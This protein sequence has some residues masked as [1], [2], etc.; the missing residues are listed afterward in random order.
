M[1]D[2]IRL[3][4]DSGPV[5]LADVVEHIAAIATRRAPGM[6]VWWHRA[7]AQEWEMV[8]TYLPEMTRED[9]LADPFTV[10]QMLWEIGECKRCELGQSLPGGKVGECNL[11]RE[12]W[13]GEPYR[14]GGSRMWHMVHKCLP[15]GEGEEKRYEFRKRRCD[16]PERRALELARFEAGV[17]EVGGFTGTYVDDDFDAGTV[18]GRR[19]VGR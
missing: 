19:R 18:G 13:A 17:V 12:A 14:M 10:D 16:G 8:A 6:S 15:Y 5:E 3:T 4:A 1:T 11:A 2:D 7:D 9:V